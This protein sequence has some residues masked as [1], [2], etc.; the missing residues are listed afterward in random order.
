MKPEEPAKQ[1]STPATN[2][3]MEQSSGESSP[4]GGS[5]NQGASIASSMPR[6]DERRPMARRSSTLACPVRLTR[7]ARATIPHSTNR[8]SRAGRPRDQATARACSPSTP[9]RSEHAARWS[10]SRRLQSTSHAPQER[11]APLAGAPRAAFRAPRA[12]RRT[13]SRRS[14]KRLAPPSEHLAPPPGPPRATPRSASHR[15]QQRLAPLSEHR[16]PLPGAPPRPFRAPPSTFSTT[17]PRLPPIFP[18]TFERRPRWHWTID[19]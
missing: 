17:A 14:H 9:R 5:F 19:W 3:V 16:A 8:R 15:P 12:P 6:T 13:T 10:T 1:R 4:P 18:L 11:L 2:L 7:M